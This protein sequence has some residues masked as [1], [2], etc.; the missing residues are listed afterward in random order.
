MQTSSDDDS[1]KQ[2]E[3]IK[4]DTRNVK[5][6]PE[7]QTCTVIKLPKST[8]NQLTN[9]EKK[10]VAENVGKLDLKASEGIREIVKDNVT[11]DENGDMDF[12]LEQLLYEVGKALYRYIKVHMRRI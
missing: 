11:T 4:V 1:L 9:E 6:E 8:E 2:K 10:Y 12:E 3:A 5:P 7:P